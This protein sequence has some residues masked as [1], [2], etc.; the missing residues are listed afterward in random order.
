MKILSVAFNAHLDK[1][2]NVFTGCSQWLYRS[3]SNTCNGQF[4]SC[5]VRFSEWGKE[6]NKQYFWFSNLPAPKQ[7]NFLV[8]EEVLFGNKC[9]YQMDIP[10]EWTQQKNTRW[11]GGNSQKS[12]ARPY[13]SPL[14]YSNQT[15]DL[16]TNGLQDSLASID[17]YSY[18]KED[19]KGIDASIPNLQTVKGTMELHEIHFQVKS[20]EVSISIKIKSYDEWSCVQLKI[21]HLLNWKCLGL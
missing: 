4:N 13:S 12:C 9:W 19:I 17:L 10:W 6:K 8:S 7:E 15:F 3:Q 14:I 1:G 2:E 11:D 16:L 18:T 20:R 5:V 21:F